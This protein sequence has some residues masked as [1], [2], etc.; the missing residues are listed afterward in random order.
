M[1]CVG[2][3]V[4]F[5]DEPGFAKVVAILSKDWVQ[6]EDE[7]GFLRD[8][9]AKL[10]A[11]KHHNTQKLVE[12]TKVPDD[13]TPKKTKEK[14]ISKTAI[15][16][17]VVDLHIENLVSSTSGW[18]NKQIVDYQLSYLK[19]RIQF[20]MQKRVKKVHIIH[21]VGAQVLRNEVHIYLRSFPNCE[22]HDAVYT[23]NGFGA[24]DFVIRYKGL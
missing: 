17:A 13:K 20:L 12:V 22:L 11:S 14:S 6:I 10:L 15:E 2:Q 24:T 5:V 9:P 21:G 16:E 8:Y 1:L 3:E 23:R 18:S 4:V 7:H 19:S